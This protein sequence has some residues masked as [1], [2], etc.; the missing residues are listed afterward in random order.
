MFPQAE[1]HIDAQ[2]GEGRTALHFAAEAYLH[3]TQGE[4]KY[5]HM[6]QARDGKGAIA[7]EELCWSAAARLFEVRFTFMHF[8]PPPKKTGAGAGG[9][10][11]AR[12]IP[13][14]KKNFSALF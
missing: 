13:C 12:R 6:I 8:S 11:W 1:A 5:E 9:R 7:F 2:D 14:E 10:H 4:I 3:D